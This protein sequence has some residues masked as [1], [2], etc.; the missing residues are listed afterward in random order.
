MGI[1]G[2]VFLVPFGAEKM[3]GELFCFH[4]RDVTES[5]IAP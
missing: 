3:S 2:E 5:V 4:M 1:F